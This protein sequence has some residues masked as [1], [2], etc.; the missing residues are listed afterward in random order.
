MRLTT[1]TGYT[2][3]V[4]IR[5]AAD[6]LMHLELLGWRL[7]VGAPIVLITVIGRRMIPNFARNWLFKRE[8][9]CL[10]LAQDMLDTAGVTLLAAVS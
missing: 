10:P 6:L 7:A 4:L 9:P 2:L 5:L 3:R 1:Y 8:R